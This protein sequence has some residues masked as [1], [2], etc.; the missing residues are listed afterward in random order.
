MKQKDI[1]LILIIAIISAV[2]S[3]LLS[4]SLFGTTGDKAQKAE[5]VD[6]V[7]V[8]FP[9]PNPKYFNENSVNPTQVIQ[10]GGSNNQNPFGSAQ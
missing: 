4:R 2:A 3:F 9:Q 5:V 6:A 10:I 7:S 1:M 8:E